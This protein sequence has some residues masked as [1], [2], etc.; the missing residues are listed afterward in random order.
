MPSL[1]ALAVE[2]YDAENSYADLVHFVHIFVIEPHPSHPDPSPYSGRVW[3][4]QYSTIQQPLTY[5]ERQAVALQ[6]EE[7][8]EGDQLLLIDDMVP[9]ALNNPVWCTYGPAPNSAYLIRQD[10]ILDTVQTWLDV[11]D[12][13]SAIDRLLGT[14]G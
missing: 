3:E 1:N 6:F 9:Q 5:A 2:S 4:A 14:G 13:R 7:R 11:D 8:L 10:G 12:M